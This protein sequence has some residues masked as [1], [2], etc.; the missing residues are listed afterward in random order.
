MGGY[1]VW[2]G[3]GYRW[4]WDMD[5]CRGTVTVMGG[6]WSVRE[7]EVKEWFVCLLLLLLFCHWHNIIITS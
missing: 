5:G 6:S 7:S 2:M 1:R 3:V 4:V